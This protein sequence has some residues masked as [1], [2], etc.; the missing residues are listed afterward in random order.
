MV[1]ASVPFPESSLRI[2]VAMNPDTQ[3]LHIW[4]RTAGKDVLFARKICSKTFSWI[5]QR[6][7]PNTA[8]RRRAG[9]SHSTRRQDSIDKKKKHTT[10]CCTYYVKTVIC[11]KHRRLVVL[12]K[13]SFT[14]AVSYQD[15]Q[16]LFSKTRGST[17]NSAW[18]RTLY[19]LKQGFS[20]QPLTWDPKSEL[21]SKWHSPL[22]HTGFGL[23]S[24]QATDYW[25]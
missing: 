18:T 5:K 9:L 11:L 6:E 7:F 10:V 24:V 2:L 4:A 20:G 8:E 23:G 3:E 14:L 25:D 16:K 17:E 22:E 13:Q 21:K 1:W 15:I 12:Q 19:F